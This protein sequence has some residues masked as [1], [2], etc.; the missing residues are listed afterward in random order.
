LEI[1]YLVAELFHNAT[2]LTNIRSVADVP[3]IPETQWEIVLRTIA[4]GVQFMNICLSGKTY[5]ENL[6][7][8]ISSN[9]K[10]SGE[11]D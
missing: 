5:R 6:Q 4:A 3:S 10:P 7:N 1:Q 2:V 9:Y 8:G 11:A